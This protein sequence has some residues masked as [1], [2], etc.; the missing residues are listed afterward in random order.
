MLALSEIEEIERQCERAFTHG[1]SADHLRGMYNYAQ[2]LK[3]V[4]ERDGCATASK[5]IRQR[6]QAFAEMHGI[7][8][9]RLT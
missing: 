9:F 8:P 5:F 7:P 2:T 6:T 1:P 3:G 4:I